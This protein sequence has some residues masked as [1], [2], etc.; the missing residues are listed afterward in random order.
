MLDTVP[1]GM[2]GHRDTPSNPSFSGHSL[3]R[4]KRDRENKK[5]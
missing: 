5:E 1:L 2:A 4:T 3:A